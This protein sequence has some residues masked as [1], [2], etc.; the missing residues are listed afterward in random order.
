MI[1]G[2]GS[3][4]IGAS[5]LWDSEETGKYGGG[6]SGLMDVKRLRF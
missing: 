6:H 1:E 2:P 5:L 4:D 3:G